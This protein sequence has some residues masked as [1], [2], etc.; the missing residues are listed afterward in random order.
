MLEKIRNFSKSIFAKILLVIIIIPFVFWGMGGVFRGGNTN[1]IVEINNYNI[2][3]QDFVDYL[4]SSGVSSEVIR[5]NID[6]GILEEIL[7]ELISKTLIKLEVKDLNILFS[8]ESLIRKIKNEKSFHDENGK[9][10]RTIYEKFLLTNNMSPTKYETSIKERELNKTLFYYIGG[11]LKSPYFL[12]NSIFKN[13]TKKIELNY[14]GLKNMYKKKDN[15]TNLE[16]TKYIDKNE[17]ELKEKFIDFKYINIKPKNLIGIDEFNDLFFEKIDEIENQISNGIG[18]NELINQL[19]LDPNYIKN[20]NNK[21]KNI[22]KKNDKIYKKIYNDPDLNKTKLLDENE[23]YVLYEINNIKKVLPNKNDK[24]FIKKIKNILFNKAKFKLHNDLIKKITDK[25]FLQTDF[26]DLAKS[27]N[28][29]INEI[30]INSI[31]NTEFFTEDSIKLI[32]SQLKNSFILISDKD[33][34]IYIAKIKNIHKK[35]LSK[36]SDNYL[37]FFNQSNAKIKNNMFSSYDI[38]LNYKYKIKVNNKTL[39]RVKNYFK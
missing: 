11:G 14:I 25:K 9:F 3:T 34:N 5:E 6:N 33:K 36:S 28:E 4:N 12:T 22:D 7:S 18:F 37:S 2:S 39:E 20:Y 38:F 1:N 16:I 27:Y 24:E 21:D 32:Y 23:F 10:S 15:F 19:K 31:D 8:N 30:T 35:N 26:N 29:K 13:Q 17:N